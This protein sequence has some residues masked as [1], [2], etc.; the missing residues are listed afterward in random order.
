MHIKRSKTSKGKINI[1]KYKLI[2]PEGNEH[3]T[4]HG[5]TVPEN[6]WISRRT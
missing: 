3:F 5:L 1:K 6:L 4:N 2:D